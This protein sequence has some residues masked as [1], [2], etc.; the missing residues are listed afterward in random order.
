M[1]KEIDKSWTLFL[2][3]DGVINERKPGDYVRHWEE[4]NFLKGVKESLRVLNNHFGKILIISNQR[5][6]AKGLIKPEELVRIHSKMLNEIESA[7]GRIDKIY[8]CPDMEGENRKPNPGM[9]LQAIKDFPDIELKKSVMVG[10]SLTDME[11]GRNLGVEIN[12]LLKSTRKDV[13]ERLPPVD[14][15]FDDLAAF[16]KELPVR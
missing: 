12:V 2:D 16:T 7:G 1:L 14:L 4:F 5:G 13:Y 11:F 3:R 6:I 15:V 10:D 9:G 8:V